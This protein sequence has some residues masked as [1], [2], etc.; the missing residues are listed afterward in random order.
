MARDSER[1]KRELVKE[2]GATTV[3]EEEGATTV[4]KEEGATGKSVRK[5]RRAS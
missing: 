3:A 5:E 4:A 2:E 1:G